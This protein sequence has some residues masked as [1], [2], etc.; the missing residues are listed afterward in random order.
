MLLV[1]LPLAALAGCKEFSFFS[2]LGDRL[3]ATPLAIS[4]ATVTVPISGTVMFTAT[5]GQS[6]YS[7]A[8]VAGA[9]AIDA[10]TGLYTAPA[11]TG[12]GSV[13]VTDVKGARSD[14]T[15]NITGTA[16]PLTIGPT[17]VTMGPGGSLTF[18]A[19]GGTAPYLFSLTTVGSGSPSIN[20]S[21]GAYTAGAST[22]TD[23]VQVQ[24]ALAATANATVAV[25]A[26]QTNVDYTVSATNFPA[27]G[28]GGSAIPGGYDFT[29]RNDG[30]A[31]GAQPISWWL[32]ISDDA[33]LGSGDSLLSGG[34]T[35]ALPS[36]AT[37]NIPLAG[38]WP[39][40]SGVKRLFV[41]VSSADDLTV[42]NNT[43]AGIALTL[44]LP[45][46]SGAAAH[47]SG[48]TAGAAFTATLTID[49]VGTAS[50]SHD[51]TW[52]VYASLGN[53]TID[54]GDKL[55]ASG[56]IAGGLP[57]P[58]SS[59]P[60]A[61]ANTWPATAGSYYL[62]ADIFAGDDGNT[63][64]NQSAS[65]SVAVTAPPVPNVDYSGTLG[66]GAPTRAGG[67]FSS[68]LTISNGGSSAGSSTVYWSVY[69]SLGDTVIDAGDKL[70]GSG[71]L[72]AL[73]SGAS[74]GVL[75]FNSSWP[76]TAGTYYLV[77]RILADDDANTLNN[78]PAGGAMTV[79]LPDVD[80]LVQNV[81]YTGGTAN[82]GAVANGSFEY[83]NQGTDTGLQPVFWTAYA[84]VNASL[85]ASDTWLASG[86]A[87]PLGGGA[88]STPAVTFSGV[89]PLDYG[90]YY[91]LVTA[92]NI[93]DLNGTNNQA[94]STVA[95]TIGLYTGA[96]AENNHEPNDDYLNLVQVYDLGVTLQP[97][98]SIYLAGDMHKPPANDP[99]D[100]LHVRAGAN[101][102]I[103]ASMSW[104]GS[105][106]VQ[107]WI[108][109]APGTYVKAVSV[110]AES[111]A[112]GWAATAGTSYWIDVTNGPPSEDL[113]PYTLII[114]AN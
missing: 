99:D 93:E 37:V 110:T 36:G 74:S 14:A 21:T 2:V 12:A 88:T 62:I 101:M 33:L 31:A 55:V 91:L 51:I 59:G 66:A 29:I 38:S 80:Y 40:S 96:L 60:L 84:S 17:A 28:T 30:A 58:G 13:R 10:G 61:I 39:L 42:G 86:T 35:A 114:T 102:T 19:S 106:Y 111:L 6:P 64:N 24:D 22:G 47:S 26:V 16:G 57:A 78:T 108:W 112:V 92:S 104:T 72:A 75:A 94:A 23:T 97:G 103:T 9:G 27:S 69:A 48:T 81:T 105:H 79:N 50:G 63:A 100:V 5:G 89:W 49:N 71:S 53:G 107:L 44:A 41:M 4:P 34:S 20:G 56:S 76:A 46:Y 7:F 68:S 95:T 11:T 67:A 90:S 15:V 43:T 52:N 85:D 65:A 18:V 73:A 98:M 87:D 113:G 3:H 32:Y 45:D 82:P 8:V 1:V 25:T 109:T 77:A 70:V 54:A 83:R